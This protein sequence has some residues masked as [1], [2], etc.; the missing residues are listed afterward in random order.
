MS[1]L[2]G[3]LINAKERTITEVAIEPSLPAYY[4]A[5]QCETIT[6]VIPSWFPDGECVYVDD[7]GLLKNPQDFFCIQGYP[8]PLAGNG[9]ILGSD[10]DGKDRSTII[11]VG[12]IAGMTQF[13]T[14]AELKAVQ[15]ALS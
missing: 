3:I 14:L 6:A 9:L 11:A 1:T 13:L 8:Q 5:L 10:V 15:G 7:E 2:R 4:R 12:V